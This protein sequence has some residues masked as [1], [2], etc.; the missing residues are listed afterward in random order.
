MIIDA[1]QHYWKLDRGDYEWLTPDLKNL[2]K[3]FLPDDLTPHLTE[4][5]ISGTIAVQAAA[6]E[7]ET[8]YLIELAKKNPSILGVVGWVDLEAIDAIERLDF[9]INAGQGLLKGIRPMIQDI[10]DPSWILK[11]KLD[12]VFRALEDRNLTF[13]ALI[14]PFHLQN[15][16]TRI[17]KHKRLKVMIDHG[18]KP[19]IAHDQRSIWSLNME[20]LSRYP[21]VYCKLSGLTTEAGENW[22]EAN[23]K[24]FM[25]DILWLFKPDRVIWGSD[26]PVLN[27]ASNYKEW[28]EITQRFCNR[29]TKDQKSKIFR[30]NAID[31]YNLDCLI[32]NTSESENE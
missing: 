29:F 2:Y 3:D 1:H 27:L 15:L 31:F 26:W 14:S 17:K 9:L 30:D 4:N 25:S 24:P 7:D 6:S 10:A 8:L 5:N 16:E 11:P 12:P 18:A 21:N 23:L 20:R 28:L 32:N 22:T 19:N 13:D